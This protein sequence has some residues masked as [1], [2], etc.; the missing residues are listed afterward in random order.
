MPTR[1]ALWT[2][3]SGPLPSLRSLWSTPT[4]GSSRI[5]SSRSSFLSF[6]N[7][8]V[9]EFVCYFM[10]LFVNS[11]FF[12]LHNLKIVAAGMTKQCALSSI[13]GRRPWRKGSPTNLRYVGLCLKC[14]ASWNFKN[15]SDSNENPFGRFCGFWYCSFVDETWA[16]FFCSCCSGTSTW[17]RISEIPTISTGLFISLSCKLVCFNWPWL[18]FTELK[19]S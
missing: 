10:F 2:Y 5:S 19:L 1:N 12:F 11:V 14:S 9:C 6:D 16:F 13:T 17:T 3:G 18:S 4:C 8:P 7:Y 15:F